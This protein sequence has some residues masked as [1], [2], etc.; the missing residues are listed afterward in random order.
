MIPV[1]ASG[2]EGASFDTIA[3][4][5]PTLTLTFDRAGRPLM[6]GAVNAYTP[7]PAIKL[8]RY[9]TGGTPDAGFGI[10]G[11]ASYPLPI[12]QEMQAELARPI[13][14]GIALDRRGRILIGGDL[15]DSV[16][17]G[18][19]WYGLRVSGDAMLADGFE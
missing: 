14:I 18:T 7:T 8:V 17:F 6:A 13:N 4:T 15:D 11:V 2:N 1:D 16:A 12:T 3:G 5:Y 19:A 10:G 9:T